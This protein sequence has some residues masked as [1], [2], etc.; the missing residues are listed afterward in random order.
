M[1]APVQISLAD[2]APSQI[3][4][5]VLAHNEEARISACLGSLPLGE[6]GIAAH[7][8]VN[9]STDNTAGIARG[10]AGVTVH[11]YAQGGKAR[12]WNAFIFGAEK[13]EADI[14]VFVDGDAEVLP[15]S[16]AAL[17]RTLEMNPAANAA[18]GFPR[19]GR[20]ARVYAAQVEQ[21]H[22]LFGDLYA[23]R[24]SFVDKL[25]RE[26]IRLPEDVIG[27]DS[28]ICALA[29]TDARDES[30]WDEARVLP[31]REAGFLCEPTRLTSA[32]LGNQYRRMLNY[33]RRH[34]Q[35]RIITQIMRH[36]GGAKD[37]PPRL[38]DHYAEWLPRWQP[39]RDPVWWWFDRQALK[40]MRSE[41]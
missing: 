19:N 9:G 36:G 23:L 41:V 13:V 16:I 6:P 1:T 32:S 2:A 3:A 38:S 22:G 14:F 27:D 30:V 40:R 21:Q 8:V 25:R 28:L 17:V 31:C 7:V 4:L 20:R 24:G 37:L 26:E 11:D 5:V 15:G 18:S 29:K 34:F 33:S 35:N 10:F 39:R 12:S